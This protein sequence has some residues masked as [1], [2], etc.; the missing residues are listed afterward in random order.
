MQSRSTRLTMIALALALLIGLIPVFAPRLMIGA[1]AIP[2]IISV[3]VITLLLIFTIVTK[4]QQQNP[5]EKRKR[6]QYAANAYEAIDEMLEDLTDEEID[7]L[8]ERMKARERAGDSTT[9]E[10][11]EELLV[12]PPHRSR[13]GS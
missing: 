2:V 13:T 10:A 8:R 5:P 1:T 4:T 12:K 3:V 7:Y 6:G 9:T 11:L